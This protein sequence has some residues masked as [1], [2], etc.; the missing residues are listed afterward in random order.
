MSEVL[1]D[2]CEHCLHKLVM[3]VCYQESTA[4][5]LTTFSSP[6]FIRVTQTLNENTLQE[7]LYK[8]SSKNNLTRRY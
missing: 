8:Y 7:Q 2:Y 5:V 4:Q 6:A 1:R 3:D